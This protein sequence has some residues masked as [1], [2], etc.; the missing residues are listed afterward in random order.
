MHGTH[1]QAAYVQQVLQ[2]Y[3]RTPGTL[4]RIL[5]DDRKAARE[6]FERSVAIDVV[7]KALVL[8]VVRRTFRDQT[9]RLDAVRSLRYFL[10]LVDEIIEAP[11]DPGYFDYLRQKL[12]AKGI[13][14]A[15]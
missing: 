4:H 10:P 15:P 7:E 9:V 13:V 5:R 2:L 6:L 3:R 11:P 12:E 14:L 1:S 8:A